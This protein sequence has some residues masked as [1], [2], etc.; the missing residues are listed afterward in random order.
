MNKTFFY[1]CTVYLT[2]CCSLVVIALQSQTK[3]GT[4]VGQFLLIEPSARIAAMGNAGAGA[5]NEVQAGYYNPAVW[6]TLERSG[7]QFTH[8]LWLADITYNYASVGV[9]TG[10]QGA[11]AVTFTS[12]SSGEIDVRTVEQPLGTGERYSVTNIALGLGYGY[13]LSDRFSA[14]IT[15]NY[16]QETIWHSSL[17]AVGLNFG[18]LFRVTSDDLYLGASLSN[19]GTR[20]RYS[21]TDLRIRFDGNPSTYGDNS[22]LPGEVYTEEYPLPILFRVGLSYPLR[23]DSK[24]HLYVAIDAL[25]PSDNTESINVGLE[26][27]FMEIVSLRG[28][29][30]QLFQRDSEI[31]LTLGMGLHYE[32]FSV[33]LHLDYAWANYKQL[34]ETQRITFGLQF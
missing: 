20:A 25:H 33:P 10:S 30:Q 8:S 9:K 29:Y 15:L 32:F 2:F 27:T 26:W 4:T 18:T 3:T 22:N 6:G 11:V 14:G 21:G 12:L 5:L 13:R 28:G 24:N 19:F 1:R 23:I 7:V 17:V 16:I 34:K 31:G